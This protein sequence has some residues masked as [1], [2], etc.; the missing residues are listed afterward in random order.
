M[1]TRLQE[2]T[3]GMQKTFSVFVLSP[4]AQMSDLGFEIIRLNLKKKKGNFSDSGSF[5]NFQPES[6]SM[7]LM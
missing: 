2:A 1:G 6:I 7:W 4:C 3:V 5:E